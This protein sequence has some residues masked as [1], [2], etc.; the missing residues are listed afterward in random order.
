MKGWRG[1]TEFEDEGGG[2]GVKDVELKF[3]W[4]TES[5]TV[6]LRSEGA[7]MDCGDLR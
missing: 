4:A 3:V 6:R 7:M 2:G 5:S 1:N